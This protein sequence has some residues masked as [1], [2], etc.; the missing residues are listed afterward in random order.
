MVPTLALVGHGAPHVP[1]HY[2]WWFP[3]APVKVQLDL[4]VVNRLQEQLQLTGSTLGG[5]GLLLGTAV[6]P[7]T[8]VTDFRSLSRTERPSRNSEAAMIPAS[9][10]Q[11]VV[12]YYRVHY[13]PVL[14]LNDDDLALVQEMFEEPHQVFLLIQ[15]DDSGPANATFFFWDDG[16]FCGDFA[17]L[18]FPLDAS[19]L[20]AAQQHRFDAAHQRVQ[21]ATL[22]NAGL[23]PPTDD[24]PTE[25]LL[26]NWIPFQFEVSWRS[27]RDQ[28]GAEGA[29][30][31]QA[32]TIPIESNARSILTGVITSAATSDHAPVIA[33]LSVLLLFF[34]FAA[35]SQ[36]RQ[37]V[38]SP[39]GAPDA[40]VEMGQTGWMSE[41]V[42]DPVGSARG[43]Q[44]SLYRPAI[45]MSDYRMEFSGRI[46]RKSLG[47]V[48]RTVDSR[49]YY[50][51]KLQAVKAGGPLTLVRFAVI[52]GVE[53]PHTE[54]PLPRISATN[55]LKVRLDAQRSQFTLY[56]QNEIA[57]SWH[58]DQLKTGM[59]GF[60]NERGERGQV[61]AVQ[62]SIQKA[63]LQ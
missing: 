6:G 56:V 5:H 40:T 33:V 60:L 2:S 35:V 15:P 39:P 62:I 12:G 55:P 51:G 45:G 32:G 42:S 50:V 17:F 7:T 44:L 1:G 49:N 24:Q 9:G 52:R 14:K 26:N 18:E 54:M 47:W 48:F 34:G 29:C 57:M 59:I 61:E 10:G 11:T 41:W 3:G 31:Q 28:P 46:E 22:R 13:D 30:L 19:L 23:A 25:V 36:M 53:G 43:R 21:S 63:G 20:A 37:P 8:Q 38:S 16:R 58:D 4:D 27:L